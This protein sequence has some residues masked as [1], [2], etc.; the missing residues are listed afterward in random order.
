[1]SATGAHSLQH[2]VADVVQAIDDIFGQNSNHPKTVALYQ[3]VLAPIA[4]VRICV[5]EMVEPVNFDAQ[6]ELPAE[7]IE[8]R[9]TGAE[10]KLHLH[11]QSEEA[12]RLGQALEQATMGFP[13]A[14]QRPRA[15]TG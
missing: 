14:A 15:P 2:V 9:W 7:Q 6:P 4:S 1:M 11:V 3:R 13:S 10:L 8:L 12:S 5:D